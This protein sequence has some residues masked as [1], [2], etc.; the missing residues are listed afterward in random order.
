MA[1]EAFQIHK[2]K[3]EPEKRGAGT[4]VEDE[5]I[6]PVGVKV[7]ASSRDPATVKG[8]QHKKCPAKR[9]RERYHNKRNHLQKM[10]EAWEQGQHVGV[11]ACSALE[12]EVQDLA[13]R[14]DAAGW[15]KGEPFTDSQGV[16]RCEKNLRRPASSPGRST[17]TASGGARR[18]ERLRVSASPRGT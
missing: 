9:L 5:D 16:R 1:Y 2:Q 13:V 10:D 12:T 4:W 8:V 11:Q 15:E 17:C 6:P 7:S 14:S 3:L 18:R